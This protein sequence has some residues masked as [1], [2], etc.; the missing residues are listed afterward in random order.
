[1]ITV[2][3]KCQH[4]QRD[5]VIK[6]HHYYSKTSIHSSCAWLIYSFIGFGELEKD[7]STI[8]EESNYDYTVSYISE[9]N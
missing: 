2:T 6:I 9:Y 3:K 5:Q 8:K 7:I 1:M 4:F